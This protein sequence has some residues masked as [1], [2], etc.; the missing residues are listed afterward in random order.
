MSAVTELLKKLVAEELMSEEL[1]GQVDEAYQFDMADYTEQLNG[2]TTTNGELNTTVAQLTEEL[3]AAKAE[4]LQVKAMNFD[5][6]V[7]GAATGTGEPVEE[8]EEEASDS[9]QSID[10][11]IESATVAKE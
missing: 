7:N 2:A 5:K 8:G 1:S 10:E 3:E 6:L 11:L 9:P 4:T